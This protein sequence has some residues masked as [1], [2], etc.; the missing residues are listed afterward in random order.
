[1]V[2]EVA[3]GTMLE[4]PWKYP[5]M[6]DSMEMKNSVGARAIM[7]KLDSGLPYHWAIWLAPKNITRQP[8]SPRKKNSQKATENTRSASRRRPWEVAVPTM[9]ETAPGM[10][11]IKNRPKIL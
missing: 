7:A 3:V 5:R 10:E 4:R 8:N 11:S 1:M 9:R 2:W 6:L